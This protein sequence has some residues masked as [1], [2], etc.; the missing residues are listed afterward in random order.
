VQPGPE[1][2]L[3]SKARIELAGAVVIDFEAAGR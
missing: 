2:A 1:Q 3:P